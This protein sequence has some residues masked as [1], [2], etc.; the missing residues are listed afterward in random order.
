MPSRADGL[1]PKICSLP[2]AELITFHQTQ[3][4]DPCEMPRDNNRDPGDQTKSLSLWILSQMPADQVSTNAIAPKDTRTKSA[5]PGC[6]IKV[7]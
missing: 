5:T 1:T 2:H 6:H 3:M 4:P 7:L